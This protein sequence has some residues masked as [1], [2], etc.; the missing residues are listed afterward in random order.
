[1][2]E[3][4]PVFLDASLRSDFRI[5]SRIEVL[6]EQHF[7]GALGTHDRDLRGGPRQV[8]V[9]PDVLGAH[10]VVGPA[11]GLADDDRDL[12]NRGFGESV[13]QLRTVAND[14]TVLLAN[15]R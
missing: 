14:P 13:E 5:L 9:S 10:D 2:S 6:P 8:H 7:D 4:G 15:P 3:L 11:V 1:M 12:R